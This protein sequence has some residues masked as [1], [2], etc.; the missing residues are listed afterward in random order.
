VKESIIIG[1]EDE[2]LSLSFINVSMKEG[3]AGI[4]RKGILVVCSTY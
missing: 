4:R 1:D 3:L 2:V